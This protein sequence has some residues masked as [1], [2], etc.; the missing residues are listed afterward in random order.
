MRRSLVF[1]LLAGLALIT[2]GPATAGSGSWRRSRRPLGP[3]PRASGH[4]RPPDRLAAGGH[5]RQRHTFYVGSIP[6][7]AVWRGDARTGQGEPSSAGAGPRGDGLEFDHGRLFVAGGG[8]GQAYVYD[9]QDRAP[10]AAYQL[11]PPRRP[12]INDVA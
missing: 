3:W 9:A 10:L 8:T 11:T 5:R 2:A 12:F 6:T 4:H 7:G 1:A